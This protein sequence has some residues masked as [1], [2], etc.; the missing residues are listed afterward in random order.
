MQTIHAARCC[1]RNTTPFVSAPGAEILEQLGEKEKAL[2]F[3]RRATRSTTGQQVSAPAIIPI[4]PP[5]LVC[6]VQKLEC[7]LQLSELFMQRDAHA[8]AHRLLSAYAAGC[9]IPPCAMKRPC[10]VS[11]L[12]AIWQCAQ[13]R[14][15]GPVPKRSPLSWLARFVLSSAG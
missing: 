3:I 8:D 11:V 15:R 12:C 9:L 10:T 6:R 5:K 13:L 4:G 2:S 1:E 14:A 7:I